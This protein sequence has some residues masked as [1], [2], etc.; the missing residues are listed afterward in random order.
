MIDNRGVGI[1]GFLKIFSTT[2]AVFQIF[3]F[4]TFLRSDFYIFTQLLN[5][6][7][8]KVLEGWSWVLLILAS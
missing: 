6:G 3:Y 7:N 2:F 1:W 8:F 4:K 5:P